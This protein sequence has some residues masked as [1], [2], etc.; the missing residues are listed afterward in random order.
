MDILIGPGTKVGIIDHLAIEQ[1][2]INS[3]GIP[4]PHIYV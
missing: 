4:P 2:K 3:N 1:S